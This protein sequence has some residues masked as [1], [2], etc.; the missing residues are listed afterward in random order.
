MILFGFRECIVLFISASV[1]GIIFMLRK[2]PVNESFR[3]EIASPFSGCSIFKFFSN[4]Y[5]EVTEGIVHICYIFNF[6]LFAVKLE[7][8][9]LTVLSLSLS[10]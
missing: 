5:I 4:C 3:T 10:V 1:I 8:V 6:S 2:F 7:P 9:P